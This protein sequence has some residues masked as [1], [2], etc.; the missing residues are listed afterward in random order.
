MGR[1]FTSTECPLT[2]TIM[3][4]SF[5]IPM[6]YMT[7]SR[8]LRRWYQWTTWR[9]G[10]WRLSAA[11]TSKDRRVS[12]S[13][14]RT[15]PSAVSRVLPALSSSTVWLQ[16]SAAGWVA[17][18]QVRRFSSLKG[19]LLDHERLKEIFHGLW[20]S[21]SAVTLPV[22]WQEGRPAFKKPVQL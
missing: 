13:H 6:T 12:F 15:A 22:E 2:P 20:V 17:V 8:W 9:T 5:S 1:T 11:L 21:F 16:A 3:N 18:R 7:R 4:I 10:R 19:Q 14:G